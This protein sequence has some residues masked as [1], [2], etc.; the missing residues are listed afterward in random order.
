MM[1]RIPPLEGAA[2]VPGLLAGAPEGRKTLLYIGASR[3]RHFLLPEL[4]NEGWIIDI[5]EIFPDNVEFLRRRRKAL[6]KPGFRMVCEGDVRTTPFPEPSYDAAFWWH[7]PE[8]IP[9]EDVPGALARLEEAARL[10]VLGGPLEDPPYPEDA[11]PGG[12]PHE[13]HCWSITVP[14]LESFGY[15]V[16]RVPRPRTPGF[17]AW[18]ITEREKKE[19][20][21]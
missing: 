12:N 14:A 5:M 1:N 9:E 20:E 3:K 19:V 21:P 16:M 7:G 4:A 17:A 13:R 2:K 15:T 11:A 6:S 18:K 10:V 8:H